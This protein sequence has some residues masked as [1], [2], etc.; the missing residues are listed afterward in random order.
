[1]TVTNDGFGPSDHSSFYNKGVPVLYFTTGV[2]KEYHTPDDDAKL[3]N[4]KGL[5][6]V[7]EYLTS[8]ISEIIES[9]FEPEYIKSMAPASDTRRSFK[10]TLGLIPDFTYEKGDG[11]RVGSVTDGRPAQIAGMKEGDIIINMNSKKINNI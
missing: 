7:T 3:I 8:I 1:M 4:F 10:V 2:H 11:F 6:M 5:T 9:R